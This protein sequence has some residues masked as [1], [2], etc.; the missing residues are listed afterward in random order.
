M[1]VSVSVHETKKA[2][3]FLLLF[4]AKVFFYSGLSDLT[5]MSS[6]MMG[7]GLWYYWYKVSTRTN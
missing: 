5:A 3:K 4:F 1:N 2:R 7:R 6:S